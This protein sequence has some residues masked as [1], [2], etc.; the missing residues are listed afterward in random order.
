MTD[1]KDVYAAVDLGSNSFHMVV[2]VAESEGSLRP[3][4]RLREPVRLAA[5]LDAHKRITP[6]ARERALACL[7]RFGERL[8]TLEASNVRAVGTNT[9]RR[10]CAAD[11]F[12]TAAEGA[13]GHPIDIISGFEEARLIYMGVAHSRGFDERPRLV[14]D[15]GGGS[16]EL[17]RG[18]GLQPKVLESVCVGCVGLSETFFPKGTVKARA[19][20]RAVMSARH[21][22]EPVQGLFAAP[23][24][25]EAVGASGTV[26]AVAAVIGARTDGPEDAITREG[27]HQLRDALVKAGDVDK[28]T[29]GALSV[30]RRPVFPG[31]VAILCALFDALG[32]EILEVSDGALREG[33]LFD[34]MGRWGGTDI[35]AATVANLARRYHVD[36]AHAERVAQ[37]AL[38]LLDQAGPAW[39][40]E[41]VLPRQML[42]WAAQLHE[43]GLDISHARFHRHGSYILC[44]SD[45]AGFSRQEQLL[46]A[47][48]VRAHR[49]KVP[50]LELGALPERW[51]DLG[52]RL[53]LLLRLAVAL[54]RGRSPEPTPEPAVKVDDRRIELR[55]PPGVLDRAPLL[56]TDLEQEQRYLRKV[57]DRLELC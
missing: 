4:D 11:A 42:A 12:L 54:H 8:R 36:M 3:I 50:R 56:R 29:A 47:T 25:V 46:L 21:E 7:E 57:G 9:L 45:M 19:M 55:F 31:G 20:E 32:I 44:H 39:G 18:A 53:A 10:A 13:L 34:L 1:R 35:R 16:T 38:R 2:A 5:G 48:L 49:R 27:L 30:D 23:A 17:I 14:V 15:I 40:L 43:I 24:W 28:A 41:G 37:S 52:W 51:V 22:L 6:E 26:R 33:A